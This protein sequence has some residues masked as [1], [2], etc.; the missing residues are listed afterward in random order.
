VVDQW[1]TSGSHHSSL[2]IAYLQGSRYRAS[3]DR[4]CLSLGTAQYGAYI[5]SCESQV[6]PCIRLL[7][8]TASLKGQVKS[9]Q[10]E[11]IGL[12]GH[13]NPAK[14]SHNSRAVDL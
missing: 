10:N 6:V 3:V 12:T 4:K 5:A 1:V 11:G 14:C 7:G 8:P 9:G 2:V 13:Q